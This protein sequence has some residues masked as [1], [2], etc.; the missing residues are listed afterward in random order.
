[1]QQGAAA[2]PDSYI[3]SW[4]A[5]VHITRHMHGPCFL[6]CAAVAASLQ[7]DR[8][9]MLAL[10]AWDGCAA[11]LSSL[12][13]S[14]AL[15]IWPGPGQMAAE[16]S[17]A[18]ACHARSQPGAALQ[19]RPWL[20][21]KHEAASAAVRM[22]WSCTC[23]C[24]AAPAT[25]ALRAI[26]LARPGQAWA[27]TPHRADTPARQTSHHHCGITPHLL[28]PPSHPPHPLIPLSLLPSSPPRPRR[29]MPLQAT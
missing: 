25:C 16:V 9:M 3:A 7:A 29:R 2:S 21:H 19:S 4:P 23:A 8:D 5:D 18:D 6:A 22:H 13:S 27:H 1:V 24:T 20:P 14:P 28:L 26:A 17:S 15:C 10:L 11:Q 12:C